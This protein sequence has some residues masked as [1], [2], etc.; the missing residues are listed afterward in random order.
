MSIF[1]KLGRKVINREVLPVV[2]LHGPLIKWSCESKW[3]IKNVI[4]PLPQCGKAPKFRQPNTCN[5][6]CSQ[7]LKKSFNPLSL[8]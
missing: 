4:S 6:V 8:K 1:T 2:K 5:S 7:L 3:Q